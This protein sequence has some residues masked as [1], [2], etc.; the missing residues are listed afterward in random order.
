MVMFRIAKNIALKI[1]LSAIKALQFYPLANAF[2]TF[3]DAVPVNKIIFILALVV[4]MV[5]TSIMEYA[6]NAL[7][8]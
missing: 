4:L 1:V 2:D 7:M 6:K 5:H 3:L 8:L